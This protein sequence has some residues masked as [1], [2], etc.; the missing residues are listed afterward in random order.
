MTDIQVIPQNHSYVKIKADFGVIQELYD[1]FSFH[2]EGYRFNPKFKY[3]SWDGKI[4]LMGLNGDLPYGLVEQLKKFCENMMYTMEIAPEVNPDP[5]MTR[6]E[7]D[8][9]L[10]SK[11]HAILVSSRC[12]V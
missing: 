12:N 4:R 9:W 8:A 1:Y 11:D 3:G 2:V 5:V 6:E 10:E 7:F